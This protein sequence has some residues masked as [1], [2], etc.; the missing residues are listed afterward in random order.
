MIGSTVLYI[1]SA[2]LAMCAAVAWA[3]IADGSSVLGGAPGL[4]VVG[5]VATGLASLLCAARVWRKHRRGGVVAPSCSREDD[6]PVMIGV[7]EIPGGQDEVFLGWGLRMTWQTAQQIADLASARGNVPRPEDWKDITRTL[8]GRSRLAPITLPISMIFEHIRVLGATGTGKSRMLE[9]LGAQVARRPGYAVVFLDPKGDRWMPHVLWDVSLKAGKPFY[10][11]SPQL[12]SISV[13]YNPFHEFATPSELPD[14]FKPLLPST[15][16]EAEPYRQT[17]LKVVRAVFNAM[18]ELGIRPSLPRLKYYTDQGGRDALFLQLLRKLYPTLGPLGG[19]GEAL[20]VAKRYIDFVIA[21]EA[22]R[23]VPP[24]FRP[25]RIA[26]D[27]VEIIRNP[28]VYTKMTISLQP[29]LSKLTDDP[30]GSLLDP[31]SGRELVTWSKVEREHAVFYFYLSAMLSIDTGNSLARA[32]FMDLINHLGRKFSYRPDEIQSTPIVLLA[33][34]FGSVAFAE[35]VE[36]MAKGRAAALAVIPAFQTMQD[37]V[38]K[39]G[40]S[41][42]RQIETNTRVVV[43]FRAGLDDA[44]S[45][46]ERIGRVPV[47]TSEERVTYT[48]SLFSSGDLMA[49]DFKASFQKSLRRS[50]TPLVPPE[51]LLSLPKWTFVMTEGANVWLGVMPM[52][53]RP[54][55]DYIEEAMKRISQRLPGSVGA[56]APQDNP[57]AG[58]CRQGARA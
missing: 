39:L 26:G 52:L 38:A 44:V 58:D 46:S 36:A 42:A 45:F 4:G 51:M 18:V 1:L 49:D 54:S 27:L 25:S 48:P 7:D 34:E 10:F 43:Q 8:L 9:L 17:Q 32:A 35:S 57:A 30:W 33:D 37:V 24:L 6:K 12:P 40:I 41:G 14:R 22:G 16:G 11:L 15:T 31:D 53:K 13:S 29:V 50:P 5:S 3:R 2:A 21:F 47:T 56:P 19:S 55:R 20:F 28:E 23:E